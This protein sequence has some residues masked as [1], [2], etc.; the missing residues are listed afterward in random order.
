M[1]VLCCNVPIQTQDAIYIPYGK[2][3]QISPGKDVDRIQQGR[4][5]GLTEE[6]RQWFVANLMSNR[7]AIM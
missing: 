1:R 5:S 6:L 2:R 4:H 3:S 7:I